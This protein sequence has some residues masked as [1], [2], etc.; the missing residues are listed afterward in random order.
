MSPGDVALWA[1]KAEVLIH[2]Q[3]HRFR[4]IA[5]LTRVHGMML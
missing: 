4:S 2:A 5:V 1:H 3:Q